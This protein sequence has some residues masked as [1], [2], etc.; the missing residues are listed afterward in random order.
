MARRRSPR[1]GRPRFRGLAPPIPAPQAGFGRKVSAVPQFSADRFASVEGS[2]WSMLPNGGGQQTEPHRRG[3]DPPRPRCLFAALSATPGG[4][5]GPV[6]FRKFRGV[7]GR[8]RAA[9]ARGGRCF[10][11]TILF[12]SSASQGTGRSVKRLLAN[13]RNTSRPRAPPSAPSPVPIP[14]GFLCIASSRQFAVA[15][16]QSPP[17]S[18]TVS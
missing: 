16:A 7:P 5:T 10:G 11:P 4:P 3:A 2:R 18:G 15:G 1:L 14:A 12:V 17:P 9:D 13:R 8:P 6:P